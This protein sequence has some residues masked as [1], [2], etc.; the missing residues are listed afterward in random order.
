MR[1]LM[2]VVLLGAALAAFSGCGGEKKDKASEERQAAQRTEQ[3]EQN[4]AQQ[5]GMPNLDDLVLQQSPDGYRYYVME[6]GEG[7]PV[8]LGQTA[9]V[10]Y[11]GWFT[12]GKKF[13]SSRDRGQPF[14]FSVG[15][16]QVIRGWDLG[17]A[18]MQV[19]ERRLLVLPPELAYG[20]RGYPGAIPPN[21]TLVFDVE[22]LDVK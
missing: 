3:Q 2:T 14:E 20:E 4:R 18:D 7:A 8:E 22:V 21:S 12:D 16:G 17:V 5:S 1:H 10:H 6:Q 15:Q 19:G 11:T 9:V 13:D